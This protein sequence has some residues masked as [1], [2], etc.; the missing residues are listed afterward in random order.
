MS[1]ILRIA[2]LLV[3]VL[4]GALMLLLASASSSSSALDEVYPWLIGASIAV[5]LV[6]AG[7]TVGVVVRV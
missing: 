3:F 4:A 5:A 1:L 6:M 7:L 2:L